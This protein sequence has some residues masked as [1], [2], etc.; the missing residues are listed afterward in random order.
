MSLAGAAAALGWAGGANGYSQ[1]VME[2]TFLMDTMTCEGA[3]CRRELIGANEALGVGA[4]MDCSPRKTYWHGSQDTGE[5]GWGCCAAPF[6]LVEE[7]RYWRERTTLDFD[8]KLG[9]FDCCSLEFKKALQ[10]SVKHR[11]YS[12]L[13]KRARSPLYRAP[14]RLPTVS[15]P[16]RTP[17]RWTRPLFPKRTMK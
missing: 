1:L 9:R 6:E 14:R 7:G 8:R 11:R 12:T 15:S 10:T 16:T 13:S 5:F 3:S 2:E 17:T 4:V